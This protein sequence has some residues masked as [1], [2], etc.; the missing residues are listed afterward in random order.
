MSMTT[1]LQAGVVRFDGGFGSQMAARG[2]L[3]GCAERLNL[4][5]PDDVLSV[6]RAYVEAGAQ[7]VETNTLGANPIRLAA[8]GHPGESAR[9]TGAAVALARA[10]GAPFVACSMGTTASFLMP[11]GPLTLAD[12]VACF[13][14]QA[15][16]ARDAGADVLL[17]ETLMSVAEARAMWIA[18]R[19]AG[20]PFAA[21]FAFQENGRTLAGDTPEACALTAAAMGAELVGVNCVGWPSVL[22]DVVRRMRAVVPTPIVAQPNAGLP[23]KQ[24]GALVYPMTPDALVA[25]HRKAVELGAS[26]IGGCCGTTPAHIRAMRDAFVAAPAPLPGGDGEIRI[27]GTR[28]V[29]RVADALAVMETIDRDGIDEAEGEAVMLDLRG[30]SPDDADEAMDDALLMLRC[31]LMLRANDADALARALRK[32]P[33]IAAYDASFTLPTQSS[34]GAIKL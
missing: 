22:L 15:D 4:T 28:N 27:C 24:N 9:I 31:P 5:H 12:A 34:Y 29:I 10:S 6:H 3:T 8:H 13:R 32:Y 30:L 19:D 20:V 33:G 17:T 1:L 23:E 18:A 14:T 2:L 7:V 25:L 16:A 21:S 26:A 11:S